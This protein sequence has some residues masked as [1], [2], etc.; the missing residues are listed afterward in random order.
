MNPEIA[1]RL[2]RLGIQLMAEA[3]GYSVFARDNCLAL[4]HRA[5]EGFRSV[6]S[7]G[8]LTENGLAYLVWR[9]E[10]ALLVAR[11]SQAP[12][13]PEQV[14]AIRTFSTDLKSALGLLL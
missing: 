9:G 5:E 2:E 8:M 1:A 10:Q 7:S 12:A 3:Q 13:R 4:A 11:N 14:E 6:G